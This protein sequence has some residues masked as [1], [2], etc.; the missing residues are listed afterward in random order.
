MD[1]KSHQGPASRALEVW[2]TRGTKEL[3]RRVAARLESM[4]FKTNSAVWFGKE[5]LS[6][7][8]A[9]ASSGPAPLQLGGGLITKNELAAQTIAASQ[10]GGD[11]PGDFA[12]VEPR[13]L[14]EWLRQSSGLAW[15]VDVRELEIAAE[16]GHRWTSWTLGGETVAFCKVGGRRVFMVDFDR[17]LDLPA[18]VAY[19]SD[20]YVVSQMRRRGIGRAL[21]AGTLGFLRENSFSGVVCHIPGSNEPSAHLF[22]SLGFA[23]LGEVRFTRVLGI[24]LF[25][26]RPEKL[27]EK[28]SSKC[29]SPKSARSTDIHRKSTS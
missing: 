6:A 1:H 21:L 9:P 22:R 29:G 2:R 25:S 26:T 28:M 15:A 8:P 7:V 11:V 4:V 18:R 10:V 17:P 14:G 20:V 13:E 24:P 3:L 16:C 23:P 5:L 27:L 19:L 12:A